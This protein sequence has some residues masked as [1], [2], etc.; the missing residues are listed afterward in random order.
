MEWLLVVRNAE[1]QIIF[2]PEMYSACYLA[3]RRSFEITQGEIDAEQ[4]IP[5]NT[6]HED[7]HYFLQVYVIL[8]NDEQVLFMEKLGLPRSNESISLKWVERPDTEKP[9]RVTI[10]PDYCA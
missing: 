10:R 9:F 5:T 3:Y 8:E 4:L 6:L 1:D 2:G 7:S